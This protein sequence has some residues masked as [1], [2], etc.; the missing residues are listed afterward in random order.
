M[1]LAEIEQSEVNYFDSPGSWL[2]TSAVVKLATQSRSLKPE[3]FCV[4][5]KLNEQSGQAT[6]H[7]Q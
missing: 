7:N 2:L 3:P 6:H 5:L 4:G 1:R